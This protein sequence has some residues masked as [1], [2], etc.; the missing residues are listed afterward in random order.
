MKKI[1]KRKG[2]G[3]TIELIKLSAENN[4]I[5]ICSDYQRVL[6]VQKMAKDLG[7]EVKGVIS[8]DDFMY[9]R[10]DMR[11]SMRAS[12][13]AS[14]ILIDNVDDILQNLC[15]PAKIEAITMTKDDEN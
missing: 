14:S 3:K 4:S 6:H 11:D 9:R 13:R 12:M 5:I 2:S 10:D 15:S 8:W 1:I 7:L